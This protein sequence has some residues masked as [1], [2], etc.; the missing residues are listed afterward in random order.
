MQQSEIFCV[1]SKREAFG[2]AN[3]EALAMGCK[4]VSTNV[5]GIPEAMGNGSFAWL[6]EP[7]DPIALEK[8][9]KL[10]LDAPIEKALREID[11]H[12]KKFSS[13]EIVSKFK[14]ILTAC[15]YQIKN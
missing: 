10:A 12:L 9:L 7:D 2:V 3:L 14:E 5:G 8:A 13:F 4:V 6:V 11:E 1:P 15:L